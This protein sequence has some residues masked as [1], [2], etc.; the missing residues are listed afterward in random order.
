M[1][2]IVCIKVVPDINVLDFDIETR[3]FDPDDF[4]YVIN[5]LDLVALEAALVIKDQAGSHEVT[6]LS[7]GPPR[8]KSRGTRKASQTNPGG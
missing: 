3:S 2:I 8:I 1:K 4:V 6:C 7:V 5:P